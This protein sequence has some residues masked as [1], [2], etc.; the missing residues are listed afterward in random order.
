MYVT[1]LRSNQARTAKTVTAED[2]EIF[3]N[4]GFEGTIQN[5]VGTYAK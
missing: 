4:L 3:S 5:R 1:L 2:A